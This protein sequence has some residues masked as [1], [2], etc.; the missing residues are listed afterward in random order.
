MRV[1]EDTQATLEELVRIIFAKAR[2]GFSVTVRIEADGAAELEIT[3]W[4][5]YRP[6]CPYAEVRD[7]GFNKGE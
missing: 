2:E 7:G 1:N 6:T 5:P 3:P 4:E